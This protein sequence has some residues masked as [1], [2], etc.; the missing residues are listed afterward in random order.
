MLSISY[1]WIRPFAHWDVKSCRLWIWAEKTQGWRWFRVMKHGNDFTTLS[2]SI[3]QDDLNY[4]VL[5]KNVSFNDI[6]SRW[7]CNV[8]VT[9]WK[10][11]NLRL[12]TGTPENNCKLFF[13]KYILFCVMSPIE[14]TRY[15]AW[16]LMTRL[17]EILWPKYNSIHR[18]FI[19]LNNRPHTA[20]SDWRWNALGTVHGF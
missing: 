5:K 3:L 12:L 19:N 15:G 17:N 2:A 6:Y 20:F 18:S 13:K 4:K 10:I 7:G 16:Q 14:S 1:G 8:T 11:L 9:W